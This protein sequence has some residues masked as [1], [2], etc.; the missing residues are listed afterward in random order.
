MS[1]RPDLAHDA[2]SAASGRVGS[3]AW[4]KAMGDVLDPVA[5]TPETPELE[6]FRDEIEAM[7]R[8]FG[9]LYHFD[10][11]PSYAFG[12]GAL[13]MVS[14]RMDGT[15]KPGGQ[16][17]PAPV[18]L[19][20]PAM[21]ADGRRYRLAESDDSPGFGPVDSFGKAR[22]LQAAEA[23]YRAVVSDEC[24]IVVDPKLLAKKRRE[25]A[26]LRAQS[27]AIARKLELAGVHA[28]RS[29]EWLLSAYGVHSGEWEDIPSFR[30]IVFIPYVAAQIRE[31]FV[32]ELEYWLQCHLNDRF[33]TLTGGERVPLKKLRPAIRRLMRRSSKLNNQD[34]MKV[35]GV[36]IV[37]RSL[38]L[39][40]VEKRRKGMDLLDD[41]GRL[42]GVI[43]RDEHGQLWFHPHLH[44]VVHLEKGRL[45]KA[46]WSAFLERVHAYWQDWMDDSGVIRNVREAVKYV[47]K[48]SEIQHL[49]P[50]ETAALYE[51]L[52]RAKLIHPMGALADAIKAR[53]AAEMTLV[54]EQ[55]ND[56][57]IWREVEDWNVRGK[58]DAKAKDKFKFRVERNGELISG[59]TSEEAWRAATKLEKESVADVCVVVARCV[60]AASSLGVKEPRVI[61]MRRARKFTTEE[62]RIAAEKRDAARVLAHPLVQKIREHT[63]EA[64]AAGVRLAA[65][66]VHTGTP[67]V[68]GSPPPK[69]LRMPAAEIFRRQ[70]RLAALSEA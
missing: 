2:L 4:M 69:P 54:R 44:C 63:R 59:E 36:R 62:G 40:T 46:E 11:I 51:Q 61:V 57:Y 27:H 10:A 30:R 34:F 14:W 60:P 6:N 42:A 65:I 45:E 35:A 41:Q 70:E 7:G 47:T 37:F 24:G 64:W 38:E 53:E 55:T 43:E 18:E 19:G 66:R 31:P 67:T 26:V 68:P 58:L 1:L 32:R 5:P 9:R 17:S 16:L 28:Y 50:Q 22:R 20:E 48:P 8:A 23:A 33:W 25:R 29:D 15:P 49:T 12:N 52:R 3:A 39:G 21:T 13:E 56:G